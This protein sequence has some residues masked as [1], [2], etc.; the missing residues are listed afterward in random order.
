MELG[1][2][3][4]IFLNNIAWTQWSPMHSRLL[5]ASAEVGGFD[6]TDGD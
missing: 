1:H 4:S 6:A 3:F 5:W 2:W